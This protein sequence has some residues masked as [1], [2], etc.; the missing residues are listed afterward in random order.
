ME[1]LD[2]VRQLKDVPP[3][4]PEAYERARATLG[5]A[6]IESGTER[7]PVPSSASGWRNRFSRRRTPR[8]GVLGKVGIGVAGAV[9]AALAVVAIDPSTVQTPA[10]DGSTSAAPAVDSRLVTLA[11]DVK[12]SGGSLP[13]DASLVVRNTTAPDGSPYVTYNLYTDKGEVYVTETGRALAGAIARGD[14]L[15][16]PTDSR[17][18]AAAREAA[19]GDLGKAKEHMVNATPN[20]W[21]LGLS[22]AEAQK[23]WDKAQA[24]LLPLLQQKGVANPQPRPRPTGKALEDGINNALWTNSLNA[25]TKGAANP[26][27]R[28]GVL[29][30]IST[31]P[32]VA[33][34]KST[35]GGQPSLVLTAGSAL[36]GGHGEH[37]LTVNAETGL[38][39]R[40]E[41]KAAPGEKQPPVAT[42]KSSRV[43]VADIVAGK[44]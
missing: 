28:A 32:D 19:S 9:A 24:E 33:V 14:N 16:D 11:A 18:M 44:F 8:V 27:V 7:A 34:T 31:I 2:L 36:F 43:T 5:T 29:R 25:L 1:D 4:R 17:V 20:S 13:G 38:P 30:L 23:V 22:P 12:A 37:V 26:E 6:I 40:S 15:A 39:I 3:L 41:G 42:Y 21:G 35:A 10:P